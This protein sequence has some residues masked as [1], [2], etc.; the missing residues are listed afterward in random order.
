M[1]TDWRGTEITEGA[2]VIYGSGVGRSIQMNEAVVISPSSGSGNGVKLRIVRRSYSSGT[3]PLVT[4][5]ADRLT[6]VESLAPCDLPTQDEKALE[7][8]KRSL[9]WSIKGL[10]EAREGNQASYW[11]SQENAI[12]YYERQIKAVTK[13]IAALEGK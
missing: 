2:L 7:S 10:A 6:V 3:Q 9:E 12:K 1:I 8:H 11:E 13:K 5:G 4:V